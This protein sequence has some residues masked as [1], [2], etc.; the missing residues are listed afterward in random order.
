MHESVRA[1]VAE[2]VR[3]HDL[4]G[5]AVLEVGSLDVNGGVRDLFTGP[6]V[7]IDMR[8]G[9]GVDQV[10]DGSELKF[11]AAAFDVVVSTETME[12]DST[13]WLSLAEIGRVLR[14]D[15]WLIMTMRGNGFGE[16]AYPSDFWRFMPASAEVLVSLA[17]CDPVEVRTDQQAP[18]L[19]I[20]GRAT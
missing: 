1:W 19:F 7:G 4:A 17:G 9:P 3:K 18:G 15:G 11:E 12:H 5:L 8:E 10:M 2:V 20:L 6:Y 13:F 16:H 14:P